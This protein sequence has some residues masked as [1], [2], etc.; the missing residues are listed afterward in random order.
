V[1]IYAK[2]LLAYADHAGRLK[3]V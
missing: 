3:D 2:A 1:G